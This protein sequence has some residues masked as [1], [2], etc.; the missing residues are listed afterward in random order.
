M[1]PSY[2]LEGIYFYYI[3]QT[4]ENGNQQ[5]RQT[6]GGLRSLPGVVILLNFTREEFRP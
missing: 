2:K 1:L 5:E 4:L 3:R 6:G